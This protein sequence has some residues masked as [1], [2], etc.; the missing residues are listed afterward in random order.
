M[1]YHISQGQLPIPLQAKIWLQPGPNYY[2]L[3]SLINAADSEKCPS[4][5]PKGFIGPSTPT[6]P[7]KYCEPVNFS[8]TIKSLPD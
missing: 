3:L 1:F 2:Y 4:Q 5:S 6:P 8:N 7:K